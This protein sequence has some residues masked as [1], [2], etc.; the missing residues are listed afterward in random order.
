VPAGGPWARRLQVAHGALLGLLWA[1]LA[2]GSLSGPRFLESPAAPWIRI[3]ACL[4]AF[5][6]GPLVLGLA[7]R[8]MASAPRR[9]PR[10]AL[11]LLLLPALV[12]A[13]ALVLPGQYRSFHQALLILLAIA[14]AG[15][16]AGLRRRIGPVLAA[17]GLISGLAGLTGL[18]ALG[19]RHYPGADPE[20]RALLTLISPTGRKLLAPLITAPPRAAWKDREAHER[21]E[22][23]PPAPEAALRRLFPGR[24]GWNLLLV[25]LDTLRADRTSL[26]GHDRPTTPHLDRLGRNAVVFERA[27]AQS[28]CSPLSYASIFTGLYPTRIAGL[29][30]SDASPVPTLARQL[31]ASG[32]RTAAV[33]AFQVDHFRS[34]FPWVEGDFADFVHAGGAGRGYAPGSEV[35]ALGLGLLP[36]PEDGPWFL[37]LHLMDPHAPYTR[38]PAH[39]FGEDLRARYDSEIAY[40]DAQLGTLLDALDCRP[41]RDR[42]LVVVHSDHGEG[43]GDHGIHHHGGS[44]HEEQIHVPLVV[45]V[46]GLAARRVQAVVELVDLLPTLRELLGL[47]ALPTHGHSLLPHLL[48]PRAGE[49]GLLAPPS[50]AYAQI[51]VEDGLCLEEA[52]VTEAEKL[53]RLPTEG[54]LLGVDLR[55]NPGEAIQPMPSGLVDRLLPLLEAKSA[56]AHGEIHLPVLAPATTLADVLAP[57]IEAFRVIAREP[58]PL[59]RERLA[60]LLEASPAPLLTAGFLA[61]HAHLDP[62]LGV[63]P[64]FAALEEPHLGLQSAALV[65]LIL[66][67]EGPAQDVLE[68]LEREN[69]PLGRHVLPFGRVLAGLGRPEDLTGAREAAAAFGLEPLLRAA[70]GDARAHLSLAGVARAARPHPYLSE[71]LSAW[72][73]RTGD[74]SLG[75]NLLSAWQTDPVPERAV[76]RCRHA[77]AWS[78]SGLAQSFRILGWRIARKAALPRSPGSAF[79]GFPASERTAIEAWLG[80]WD[81]LVRRPPAGAAALLRAADRLLA[82][83]PRAL[84]RCSHLLWESI[85]LSWEAGGHDAARDLLAHLQ[86]ESPSEAGAWAT[87]AARLGALLAAPDA[88]VVVEDARLE[89]TPPAADYL[90]PFPPLLRGRLRKDSGPILGGWL[91]GG[92]LVRAEILSEIPDRPGV[93]RTQR[94]PAWGVLPGEEFAI[95][96]DLPLDLPPG[97]H[98]VR[99]TLHSSPQG[100]LPALDIS[101][102]TWIAFG[103]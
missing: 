37:W 100:R 5:A 77:A 33:T 48:G 3:A 13:D 95:G 52:L 57:L 68:R 16:G 102:E 92:H 36:A 21:I 55:S 38:H 2:S 19:S 87:V 56:L 83:R 39:D 81:D 86:S 7:A 4:L 29:P 26:L 18:L 31:A 58:G 54:A 75:L 72:A 80:A 32:R 76:L 63:P 34:L 10:A 28:P 15:L 22:P 1:H 14:A 69:H 82:E 62:E 88:P 40:A 67:P 46:P 6:A 65:A 74:V 42:T 17:L 84:A 44:L 89:W 73:G 98:Q 93:T 47:E 90:L 85:L 35:V 51:A 49:L 23:G 12:L 43:L 71:V 24:T 25:S 97:T 11:L 64:L 59:A 99:A 61:L 60:A 78:S 50:L 45:Q 41:D 53:R 103:R 8:W 101:A 20:V 91:R 30:A 94:L 9:H 27:Y 66:V 79:A 96:L 70:A